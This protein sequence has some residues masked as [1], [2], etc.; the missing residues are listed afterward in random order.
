MANTNPIDERYW[1][2]IWALYDNERGIE[3]A[4]TREHR[5]QVLKIAALAAVLLLFFAV[6]LVPG[7]LVTC[8]SANLGGRMVTLC[9]ALTFEAFRLDPDIFT[10]MPTVPE[11]TGLTLQ[12]SADIYYWLCQF[13]YKWLGYGGAAS[14]LYWVFFIDPYKKLRAGASH[15]EYIQGTI[16]E[17][18]KHVLV[19][20]KQT[21][22]CNKYRW[23][24]F[25]YLWCTG[26]AAC[27]L[28]EAPQWTWIARHQFYWFRS[29]PSIVP[30]ALIFLLAIN[31]CFGL[32]IGLA[33]PKTPSGSRKKIVAIAAIAACL[34]ATIVIAV[35]NAATLRDYVM[36]WNAY[37]IGYPEDKPIKDYFINWTVL[38]WALGIGLSALAAWLFPLLCTTYQNARFRRIIDDAYHAVVE[39]HENAWEHAPLRAKHE[40][41]RKL[42]RFVSRISAFEL[43]FFFGLTLFALWGLYFYWGSYVGND[44]VM[45]IGIGI[46]AFEIIWALFL[47]PVAHHKLEKNLAYQG[48]GVAWVLSEDRGIGS[49]QKYW[50]A[51]GWFETKGIPEDRIERKKELDITKHIVVFFIIMAICILGS[52]STGGA[53]FAGLFDAEVHNVQTGFVVIFLLLYIFY[54]I[55][56]GRLR[57][58]IKLGVRGFQ[59]K[60]GYSTVLLAAIIAGLVGVVAGAV[61][62]LDGIQVAFDDTSALIGDAVYPLALPIAILIMYYALIWPICIRLGAK[63]SDRQFWKNWKVKRVDRLPPEEQARIIPIRRFITILSFIFAL[64][65]CGEGM[66]EGQVTEALAGIIKVN[67]LAIAGTFAILYMIISPILLAYTVKILKFT[68]PKDPERGKKRVYAILFEL[69]VAGLVIGIAFVFGT[70][71]RPGAGSSHPLHGLTYGDAIAYF[72]VPANAMDTVI[73]FV[74]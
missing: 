48:K 62:A 42:K 72:L 11:F 18:P 29:T 37:S 19:F 54:C 53:L 28:L 39:R 44:T 5:L 34:F 65:G 73:S 21:M 16:Y 32:V 71:I 14:L 20:L 60:P 12:Q 63:A 10:K 41:E 24:G 6:P 9:E 47:S 26:C 68:D 7:A 2:E 3:V 31:V 1:R 46:M 27:L 58:N 25:F 35:L 57:T 66:G 70:L 38:F 69:F 64:W 43:A 17:D 45:Y 36:N 15:R 56:F 50:K 52:S 23:I 51:V 74:F 13:I 49:W 22:S 67:Q 55:E 59:H 33:R 30:V 40:K 4:T 61:L 8:Q